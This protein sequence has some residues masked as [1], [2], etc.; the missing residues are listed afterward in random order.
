MSARRIRPRHILEYLALRLYFALSRPFSVETNGRIAAAV[1]RRLGPWFPV[2][3]VARANL[4]AAFP[5]KTQAEVETVVRG[6]WDNLARTFAEYPHLDELF[7]FTGQ[8]DLAHSRHIEVVGVERFLAL[9]DDGRP[10][11]MFAA[12]L[13]NWEVPAVAAAKFGL[14]VAVMFRPP[15]NRLAADLLLDLRTR[16]MGRTIATRFGA[17]AE[18]LAE[19]NRGGHV[20]MLVDTYLFAGER[21]AFFG[22]E[23]KTPMTLARLARHVDCPVVGVRVE[24]LGGARFRL[25]VTPPLHVPR[26]DD[27]DADARALMAEVNRII[28]TWVRERP[29]QWNWLHERWRDY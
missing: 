26:T 13:A 27:A 12:H 20:G 19:L 8:G 5:E 18:A 22:R 10:A 29:E 7:D 3:R 24:R 16:R 23:T 9:R 25:T 17:A 11:L 1:A 4:H 15:N 6:V 21:I 2:S 28:E 14:D